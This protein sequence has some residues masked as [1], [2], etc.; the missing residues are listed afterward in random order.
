MT[1]KAQSKHT[2]MPNFFSQMV[3]DVWSLQHALELRRKNKV[4]EI[5][6]HPRFR[7]A[8]DFMLLRADVGKVNQGIA[9][10]WTEVQTLEEATLLA[11]FSPPEKN[12]K[13]NK[14]AEE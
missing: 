12:K 3:R 6:K 13:P 1:L 4:L 5:L 10:F 14:A 9:K 11:Q 7:A 8:Y 2:S